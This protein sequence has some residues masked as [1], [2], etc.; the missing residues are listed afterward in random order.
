NRPGAYLMFVAATVVSLV[1][2]LATRMIIYGSFLASGY[3]TLGEW[4]WKR[5]WLLEVLFSSNHGLLAWTPIVGLA[6]IGL[7][8]LT[9][10][11]RETAFY[12]G[13]VYLVFYYLVASYPTWIA[14]ALFGNGCFVSITPI[15]VIGFVAL[16]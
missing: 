11:D 12:F 6:L 7:V 8:W 5:P 9:S 14:V 3:P 2:T 16:L 1:P 15:F 13:A 10:V 4:C